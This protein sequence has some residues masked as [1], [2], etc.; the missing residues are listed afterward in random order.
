[1]TETGKNSSPE[2]PDF[3]RGVATVLEHLP[4]VAFIADAEG[5]LVFGNSQ[6]RAEVPDTDDRDVQE[7]VLPRSILKDVLG[8][9][10][11]GFYPMRLPSGRQGG[12]S[13]LRLSLGEAAERYVMVRENDRSSVVARFATA[14]EGLLRSH[15]ERSR[16]KAEERRLR[17]EADHWRLVSM[18]DRL[19][20]LYNATGFRDRASAAMTGFEF[21]AL[22]YADLNGF[23]AINDTLG[24]A[25]GD[26]LLKDIGHTLQ[27]VI[28]A[29]DI[30]GRLGGD[31]FGVY[32][33]KCPE[34]ELPKVVARIRQA[35]TRR[36]PIRQKGG[37][38]AV[39]LSVTPSLGTAMFPDDRLQLDDLLQLADARMYSEKTEGAMRRGA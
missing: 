23:K 5:K 9:T 35:M 14:Q 20:G 36:F 1:M 26:Q 22:V 21:G 39:I 13:C 15:Q 32:L 31:E 7:M 28:R 19:T 34:K 3:L 8:T 27:S 29:G 33:P 25:A 6:F 2:L 16:A 30:A 18:S 24:H 38:A 37:A 10:V 11:P 17:A 12:A 4:G